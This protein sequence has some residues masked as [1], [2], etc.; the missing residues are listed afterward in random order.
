MCILMTM[1]DAIIKVSTISRIPLFFFV[2]DLMI[3]GRR[4]V[5]A[6]LFVCLFSSSLC[7][8]TE[9]YEASAYWTLHNAW[10]LY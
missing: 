7:Y 3:R 6:C 10:S 2:I 1:H 4:F 9:K 8:L 5:F